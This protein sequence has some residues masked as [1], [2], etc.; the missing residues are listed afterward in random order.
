MSVLKPALLFSLAHA[1]FPLFGKSQVFLPKYELGASVQAMI[2]QGDLTPSNIGSYRTLRPGILFSGSRLVNRFLALRASLLYGGLRG[3]DS[4]YSKP[5]YRQQRN[6]RFQ[7]QVFEVQAQVVVN[8]LGANYRNQSGLLSPYVATGLGFSLLNTHTDIRDYNA[9]FFASEPRVA[10]GLLI[11]IAHGPSKKAVVLPF[12]V[13]LR[14]GINENL[15]FVTETSYRIAFTDYLD[16]FSRA[17]GPMYRDNYF[18]HSI[19]FVYRFK[20]NKA[21]ACPI[22]LP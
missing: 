4:R 15:S 14:Y 16:G 13:G 10:E 9:E 5:A 22:V 2:Y 12:G 20:N 11:D 19:G 3:N 6:F 21:L 1:L 8:I 17:A 7:S 18:S